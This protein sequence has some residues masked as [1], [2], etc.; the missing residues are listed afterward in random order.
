MRTAGMPNPCI[1]LI[2]VVVAISNGQDGQSEVSV[3]CAYIA[4]CSA[5]VEVGSCM[6]CG[7]SHMRAV[8]HVLHGASCLLRVV[9]HVSHWKWAS[10]WSAGRVGACGHFSMELS[11][12][13]FME[14]GLEPPQAGKGWNSDFKLGCNGI[15]WYFMGN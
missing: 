6:L 7:A 15:V 3:Q 14:G 4:L 12:L 1:C 10:Q 13:T 5:M 8:S 2:I 11:E 9:Y